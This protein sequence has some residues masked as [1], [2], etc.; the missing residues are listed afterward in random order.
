MRR[1]GTLEDID[2]HDRMDE[3]LSDATSGRFADG[4]DERRDAGHPRLKELWEGHA[5]DFFAAPE[6]EA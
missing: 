1:S 2:L 6:A 5:N 3:L 4:W